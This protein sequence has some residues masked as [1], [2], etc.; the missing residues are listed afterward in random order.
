MYTSEE[1]TSSLLTGSAWDRTLGW[2]YETGSKTS[3][4]I[5]GDSSS[6][7]NY[8]NDTFSNTTSLINTG[9]YSETEVN[10]IFDLAGNLSEWTTE[11]YSADHRVSRGRLLRQCWIY[12]SSQQSR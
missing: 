1:F 6:W 12:L 8:R 5:I 11:A 3:I 7:G 2:L 4:E 9:E 10:H